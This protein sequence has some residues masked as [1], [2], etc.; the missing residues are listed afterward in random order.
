[1]NNEKGKSI[2]PDNSFSKNP[3][4]FKFRRQNDKALTNIFSNKEIWFFKNE[5]LKDM[6]LLE[7]NLTD[8]FNSANVNLKDEVKN[9]SANINSLEIKLKELSTK[10]TEDNSMKEKINNLESIKTKILDNI[11]V[12]DVKVN[13]LEREIHESI[14][15]VN[16]TL[17]ETVIYSGVIG[18][19]CKFKTFH[20]FIDFVINEINVLGTIKDKNMMDLSSFK[21]KI[22]SS[23]QGFKM[24]IESF[25]RSST[26]YT[27][28]S[29]NRM[30]KEMNALFHKC[31]DKIDNINSNFDERLIKTDTKIDDAQNKLIIEINEIKDRITS[32][33]K[34]LK[35]HIKHYLSFKEDMSKLN[36]NMIKRAVNRNS[37]INNNIENNS[38]NNNLNKNKI[39]KRKS[40][41]RNDKNEEIKNNNTNSYSKN[42]INNK[43]KNDININIKND[44]IDSGIN[45]N[46]NYNEINIINKE[47][48][49]YNEE[50][51]YSEEDSKNIINANKHFNK[52]KNEENAKSSNNLPELNN[53]NKDL[54]IKVG[55]S[56]SFNLNKYI[57]DK[58]KKRIE[59]QTSHIYHKG[60]LILSRLDQEDEKTKSFSPKRK[61]IKIKSIKNTF[62]LSNHSNDSVNTKRSIKTIDN[63][64]DNANIFEMIKPMNILNESQNKKEVVKE[65]QNIKTPRTDKNTFNKNIKVYK[66]QNKL[67]LFGKTKRNLKRQNSIN[68]INSLNIE[69]NNNIQNILNER[70][71]LQYQK[72]NKSSTRFKNIILTLEGT[73][74]MIY[75]TKDFQKGK[76]IYHI[77][78]LSDKNGKKTYLR[79]RLESCKSYL[80]NN[81]YQNK[82]NSYQNMGKEEM[83]DFIKY[84]NHKILLNKSASSK[85]YL[86]NKHSGDYDYNN[87]QMN[88]NLSPSLNITKYNFPKKNRNTKSEERALQTEKI[89]KGNVTK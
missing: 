14:V 12:N 66:E 17:R 20:D 15:N 62:N 40:I 9:I 44:N 36:E 2:S 48:N 29:F 16:N 6:K 43:N 83:I 71:N 28:D 56:N 13:T 76:N 26:Q 80:I 68:N 69:N 50:N 57:K 22:E 10:I 54:K 7:K 51:V 81:Y 87:I 74:K 73:K 3:Q 25:G 39:N 1:M 77:E 79:E 23:V 8:K 41:S 24:Q 19:S 45:D 52:V 86:K 85:I 5:I 78:S 33:E 75:E 47:E 4:E 11:L 49:E 53:L 37:V 88:N 59:N 55:S 89:I 58:V 31:D 27:T 38:A 63:A 70:Y 67:W 46:D 82:I 65:N 84:K 34:N 42:N 35:S 18:P 32:L 61:S 64:M 72:T 21:K 30:D 60:N